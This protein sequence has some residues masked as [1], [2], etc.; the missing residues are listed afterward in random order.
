MIPHLLT[1]QLD[2][3]NLN[4]PLLGKYFDLFDFCCIS[5]CSGEN[6]PDGEASPL[7]TSLV[8][9]GEASSFDAR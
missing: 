6:S 3:I 8:L 2:M 5:R 7:Q 1:P 4:L 9:Q